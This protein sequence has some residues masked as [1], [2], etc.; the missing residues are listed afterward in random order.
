MST[1]AQ[2]IINQIN[3]YCR[4]YATEFFHDMNGNRILLQLVQW[5]DGIS[6]GTFQAASMVPVTRADFTHATKC[7]LIALNGKNLNIYWNE[8]NKWI[9]KDAGEWTDLVGGGFQ[10]TIDGFNSGDANYHF[11]CFIV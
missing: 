9:E 8:G 5:I 4:N 10:I 1:T 2:N 7:P 6:G 11:K 3:K